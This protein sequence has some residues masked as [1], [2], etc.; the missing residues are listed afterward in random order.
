[1]IA[2]NLPGFS[3]VRIFPLLMVLK[4]LRHHLT[5]SGMELKLGHFLNTEGSGC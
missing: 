2:S 5:K 4:S 3:Q 1:M